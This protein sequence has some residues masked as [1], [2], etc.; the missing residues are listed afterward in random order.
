MK[1][2]KFLFPV[3]AN[4]AYVIADT[5]SDIKQYIRNRLDDRIGLLSICLSM[6][7]LGFPVI[8][9]V[10]LTLLPFMIIS[11]LIGLFVKAEKN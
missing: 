11:L 6:L 10:S 9:I 4:Y 8:L 3:F 1:I 2:I 5:I 7:L